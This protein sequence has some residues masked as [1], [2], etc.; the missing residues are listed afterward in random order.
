MRT[1][2]FWR[3]QLQH[4]PT[5][6]L[7]NACTLYCCRTEQ[8][9]SNRVRMLGTDGNVVTL[10][11]AGN[12]LGDTTLATSQLSEPAGLAVL[13]TQVCIDGQHT[14]SMHHFHAA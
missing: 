7:G 1:S 3:E 4:V 6:A 8:G 14:K 2:L 13:P 11:G 10:A 5:L 9:I 12:N